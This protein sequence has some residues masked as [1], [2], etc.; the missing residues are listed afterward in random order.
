MFKTILK[1]EGKSLFLMVNILKMKACSY[2][3]DKALCCGLI[4][5]GNHIIFKTQV[6]K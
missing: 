1:D 5:T 3:A 6:S 2:Q 4:F